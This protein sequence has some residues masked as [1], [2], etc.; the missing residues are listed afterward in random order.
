MRC[1]FSTDQKCIVSST[2]EGV[3]Q[4]MDIQ[5]KQMIVAFDTVEEMSQ[6]EGVKPVT[7]N[8]CFCVKS[9]KNHPDGG[10][11]FAVGAEMRFINICDYDAARPEECR[12][13]TYGKYLGHHDSV[14]SIEY[15]EDYKYLLSA[16]ADHT[17]FLW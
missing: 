5:T 6:Q 3:I 10:N 8:I 15:S 11:R 1:D 12:L 17:V 16:S 7:S 9:L 13:Q 4:V 2:L 14:R